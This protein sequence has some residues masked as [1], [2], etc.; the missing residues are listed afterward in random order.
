LE[1]AIYLAGPLFDFANRF[2]NI[3]LAECLEELGY[4]V[5]LPQ[6]EALKAYNGEGFDIAEIARMCREACRNPNNIVVGN[7]DGPEPDCGTVV[8]ITIGHEINGVAF[9]C[10]TDFRTF[11]EKEV[12]VN[13]M[14]TGEGIIFIYEPCYAVEA[15]DLRVFYKRLAL[16]IH[17]EIMKLKESGALIE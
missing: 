14:L 17:E 12:G 5:I 15:E 13:A 9:Y 1:K 10:R 8:E 6:R 3:L 4:E 7:G 2:R 11:P 16:R